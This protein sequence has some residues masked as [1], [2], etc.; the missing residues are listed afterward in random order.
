LR[1][2]KRCGEKLMTLTIFRVYLV[3]ISRIAGLNPTPLS[4]EAKIDT[5]DIDYLDLTSPQGTA[6]G[7]HKK[8]TNFCL[9]DEL[10]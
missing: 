9:K 5:I 3:A 6:H 4:I 1:L 8:A 10:S 2:M 7:F